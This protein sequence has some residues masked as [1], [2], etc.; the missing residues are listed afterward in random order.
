MVSN[1][2]DTISEAN[3]VTGNNLVMDWTNWLSYIETDTLIKDNHYYFT[4]L[5][6]D[7]YTNVAMI[8]VTG[9]TMH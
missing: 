4:L 6:R 2:I 5:V 8:P 9:H 1:A 7:E 3:A